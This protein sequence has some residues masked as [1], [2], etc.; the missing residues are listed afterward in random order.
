[1]TRVNLCDPVVLCDRHLR[2][3]TREILRIPRWLISGK[4][5]DDPSKIPSQYTV[6]LSVNPAGG[7]GHMYFFT[8]KL[9]YVKDRYDALRAEC[10][11]RG[12]E[13]SAVDKW[14]KSSF[15]LHKHLYNDYAPSDDDVLLNLRRIVE[16]APADTRFYSRPAHIMHS[17]VIADQCYTFGHCYLVRDIQHLRYWPY[18]K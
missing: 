14:P 7:K 10:A 4:L 9:Q 15:K 2:A 17:T 1:M 11:A 3:E 13:R 16:Q 18:C 12:F 8:D 6:R 5:T